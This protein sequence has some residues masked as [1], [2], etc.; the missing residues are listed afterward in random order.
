MVIIPFN[1]LLLQV[2]IRIH[3]EKTTEYILLYISVVQGN[4]KVKFMIYL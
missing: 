2:F 1:F 4:V 3:N